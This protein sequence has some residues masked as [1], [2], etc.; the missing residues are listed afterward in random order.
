MGRFKLGS[1]AVVVFGKD[2]ML[3]DEDYSAGTPTM[4]GR[5]LGKIN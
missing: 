5:A 2:A 4:M 1:T 3:W